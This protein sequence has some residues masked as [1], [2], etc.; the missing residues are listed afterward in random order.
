MHIAE[1]IKKT[2]RII[3]ITNKL[4]CIMQNIAQLAQVTKYIL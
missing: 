1:E 3:A 4:K 2:T